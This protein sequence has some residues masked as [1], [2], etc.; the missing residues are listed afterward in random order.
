MLVVPGRGVVLSS[1]T[2]LRRAVYIGLARICLFCPSE[3]SLEVLVPLG[4]QNF[5]HLFSSG[6]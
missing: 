6:G 2:S 1:T 4:L 3:S 5:L